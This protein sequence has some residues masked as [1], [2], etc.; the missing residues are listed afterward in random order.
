MLK[1][2]TKP[3]NTLENPLAI[4]VHAFDKAY[5]KRGQSDTMIKAGKR[6]I[7]SMCCALSK[8]QEIAAPMAAL[9]LLRQ[10]PFYTSTKFQ[11]I[12]LN[13]F[14]DAMFSDDPIDV[15]LSA[16]EGN[17]TYKPTSAVF[18]YTDLTHWNLFVSWSLRDVGPRRKIKKVNRS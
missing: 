18:D 2:T 6:C 17:S 11:K 15:L 12:F 16:S 10:S 4:H 7:Q 1:Y 5:L 13:A 8:P 9:Y 14:I 3:Q